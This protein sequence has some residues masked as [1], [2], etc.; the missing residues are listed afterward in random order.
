MMSQQTGSQNNSLEKT[1]DVTA[2]PLQDSCRPQAI[3]GKRQQQQ[4][5]CTNAIT[6]F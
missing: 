3:K 6:L 1:C 2:A 5:Q 4:R